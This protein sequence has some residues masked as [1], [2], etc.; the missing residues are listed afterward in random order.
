MHKGRILQEVPGDPRK[1]LG[2]LV[3]ADWGSGL[4]GE[5]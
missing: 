3:P 1:A 4:Y 2:V 5:H